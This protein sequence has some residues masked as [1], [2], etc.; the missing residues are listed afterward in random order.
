MTPATCGW[1]GCPAADHGPVLTSGNVP[2]VQTVPCRTLA[3]A[4]AR[5][6]RRATPGSTAD[7]DAPVSGVKFSGDRVPNLISTEIA[8]LP[9]WLVTFIGTMIVGL[10]CSRAAGTGA[11]DGC[12]MVVLRAGPGCSGPGTVRLPRAKSRRIA[13]NRLQTSDP[14]RPSGWPRPPKSTG[15]PIPGSLSL[16]ASAAVRTDPC[17]PVSITNG[18]GPFPSMQTLAIA[19]TWD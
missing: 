19:A 13:P 17:A 1:S 5:A 2:I 15:G 10:P 11:A 9:G 14:S 3:C 8:V 6:L 4:L 18:N 16:R 7:C 12:E